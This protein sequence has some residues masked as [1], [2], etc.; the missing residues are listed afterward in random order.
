MK[1]IVFRTNIVRLFAEDTAKQ[2]EKLIKP[3]YAGWTDKDTQ[4]VAIGLMVGK[5]QKNFL[6]ADK[7]Y[8]GLF[9]SQDGLEEACKRVRRIANE[10]VPERCECIKG[11]ISFRRFICGFLSYPASVASNDED[12]WVKHAQELEQKEK[13]EYNHQKIAPV[14]LEEKIELP[15][16]SKKS[17]VDLIEEF[18]GFNTEEKEIFN[19][20]YKLLVQQ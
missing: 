4:Q 16:K 18:A 3:H 11:N 19:R 15:T 14:K 6:W 1:T 2:F 10:N 8:P 9:S 20:M 7:I 12:K 5:A 17:A 13:V